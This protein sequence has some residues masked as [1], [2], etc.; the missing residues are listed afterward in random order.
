MA[1]RAL[2][3]RRGYSDGNMPF[4]VAPV[5]GSEVPT[6]EQVDFSTKGR[7]GINMLDGDFLLFVLG[8][9]KSVGT[10]KLCFI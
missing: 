7:S 8:S 2:H 5:V 10:D 9:R 6:R 3:L 4:P 1:L